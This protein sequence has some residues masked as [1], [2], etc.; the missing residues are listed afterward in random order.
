MQPDYRRRSLLTVIIAVLSSSTYAAGGETLDQAMSAALESSLEL[1]ADREQLG[2]T[3]QEI[4]IGQAGYFPRVSLQGSASRGR[5][6]ST[7]LI[8]PNPSNLGLNQ[9]SAGYSVTLEQPLFDGLRTYNAVQEARETTDAARDQLRSARQRVQLDAVKAYM[10]LL[11]DRA[12]AGLLTRS[13]EML[14]QDLDM[15]GRLENQGQATR[16]DIDQTTA[17]LEAARAALAEAEA[18]VAASE[19]TYELAVGHAPAAL[20]QPQVPD[21][22]LPSSLPQ[23]Q[24]VVVQSHPEFTAALHRV[25]AARRAVEK[26]K[27]D[28]L[29]Q[30]SLDATYART[31]SNPAQITDTGNGEVSVQV[32]LPVSLGGE[33]I[34][35]LRQ[36][37]F[38]LRQRLDEAAAK[39]RE[40]VAQVASIWSGLAGLRKQVELNHRSAVSSEQA[41]RGLRVQRKAGEKTELDV[42]NAEADLVQAKLSE[43]RSRS[44]LVVAAYALLAGTGKLGA[45]AGN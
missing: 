35:K 2:A 11:R 16:T 36:A 41:L 42:L 37:N 31:Y 15:T 24:S 30:V 4:A 18:T 44:D 8:A 29:P 12:T 19:V 39:R 22:A 32:A 13:A 34:A 28:F 17:R 10:A 33:T 40:L 25:N 7:Q 20:T 14:A 43:I 23:A 9:Q 1:A 26:V 45:G 5:S 38:V 21:A 27:A 3:G 6:A